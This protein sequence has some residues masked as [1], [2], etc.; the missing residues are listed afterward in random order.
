ME[1]LNSILHDVAHAIIPDKYER[2][3]RA[4]LADWVKFDCQ[5]SQFKLTLFRCRSIFSQIKK[6]LEANS[7]YKIS[8]T[9]L[10]GSYGKKTDIIG[11][12][13]DIVVFIQNKLPPFDNVLIEFEDIL[14]RSE[15]R[16]TKIKRTRYSLQ[17]NIDNYE[18]DLLPAT[19]FVSEPNISAERKFILQR[20]RTLEEMARTG[21]EY[22]FSSS[23]AFA[24]VKFMKKQS[25]FVHL[26]ARLAK[27]W[28]KGACITTYVSGAKYAMELIA[29]YA[30]QC[31]ENEG[32]TYPY[33]AAF[34]KFLE[35]VQDFRNIDI[36]FDYT[37]NGLKREHWPDVDDNYARL[38]DPANPYNNLLGGFFDNED[39][40]EELEEKA[41]ATL[42]R[43]EEFRGVRFGYEKFKNILDIVYP[44][45]FD[46]LA[47]DAVHVSI[48]DDYDSGLKSPWKYKDVTIRERGQGI[49]DF[50]RRQIEF[51][52]ISL[53]GLCKQLV[54]TY[55]DESTVGFVDKLFRNIANK[56]Q[57]REFNEKYECAEFDVSIWLYA[58]KG[59]FRLSFDLLIQSDADSY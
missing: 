46:V 16:V 5:F 54:G 7:Q 36:V 59:K 48:T 14:K 56:Y 23:L 30:G 12:D 45:L 24:T 6:E 38:T 34:E 2:R 47:N 29:I 44:E 43:M 22:G 51:M 41:A 11:S 50:E 8:Q 53:S 32:A 10:A 15:K 26:C 27:Y 20:R 49:G 9:I 28:Y 13:I 42:D 4:L 17:F 57:S 37:Y 21:N 25:S 55:Y 18:F 33:A 3:E 35:T 58:P 52:Y 39:V 31:V 19:D 1:A 40:I